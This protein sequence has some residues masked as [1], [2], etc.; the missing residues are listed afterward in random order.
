MKRLLKNPELLLLFFILFLY[1]INLGNVALRDW[2]EGYQGTVAK[3]MYK[4]GNLL[5][6]TYL[7]EPFF[8][9]PPIVFWLINISYHLGGVSEFTTRLPCAFLSGC[10]VFFLYLL[11]KEIFPERRIAFQVAIVYLTLLPVVRHNRLA[12]L[13]GI[14]NTFFI[15]S[16]WSIYKAKL[17]PYWAI[18]VGI[19][20]GLVALTK[21]ILVLAFLVIMIVFLLWDK[22]VKIFL[23]HFL[24]LGF[25]L[26]FLPVFAWYFLQ[27]Q[28]YGQAFIDAHFTSQFVD[29]VTTTLEGHKGPFW[30]YGLELIKYSCP[31][32]LF[33][34][35]ALVFTKQSLPESWAKLS[36]V[37]LVLYL[38]MISLMQTKLPWYIIPLYPFLALSIGGYL[39]KF[40]ETPNKRVSKILVFFFYLLS[41]LVSVGAVYLLVKDRQIFLISLALV[42]AV[43]FY[44]TAQRL[45][46]SAAH[47]LSILGGGM[48]LSLC[49]FMFSSSWVWE[50]KEA[51]PVKPVATLIREHTPVNQVVYTSFLYS[52]PSLDF[53]SERKVLSVDL[54]KLKEI[55]QDGKINYLLLEASVLKQLKLDRGVNLGT[56]EIFSLW[57]T[58]LK[59]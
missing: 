12:M 56:A 35:S 27:Y 11:A 33:L 58:A 1:L 47:S 32:L 40:E 53:Y 13:D 44:I 8:L 49:L 39:R 3:D 38:T 34:P 26:G 7:G 17:Q 36:L 6:P 22:Q 59:K 37:G 55:S 18:G 30:Y 42:L 2:D 29:R 5:Y 28:H 51:F 50:L 10:G 14:A 21:G 46:R 25:I 45:R 31:W 23:N 54:P 57:K 48:Y 4:T 15:F 20:L 41:I 19:G 16:F 43:T 52:R 9:K 24:P